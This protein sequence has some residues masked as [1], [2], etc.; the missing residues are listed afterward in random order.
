MNQV[1]IRYANFNRT[2]KI[3]G[4]VQQRKFIRECLQW[5]GTFMGMSAYLKISAQ[6]SCDFCVAHRYRKI[7][8]CLR[9]DSCGADE[10]VD[11]DSKVLLH[12]SDVSRLQPSLSRIRLMWLRAF[13]FWKMSLGALA[14]FRGIFW[15]PGGSAG[16]FLRGF[17]VRGSS[18]R[19]VWGDKTK[20]WHF[21][22][23]LGCVGMQH[24]QLRHN[25]ATCSYCGCKTA[26]FS[27]FAFLV[28]FA[29]YRLVLQKMS[30]FCVTHKILYCG[31]GF[32][33][34]YFFILA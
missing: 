10:G 2:S 12:L 7:N 9:A 27:I 29:T 33:R 3:L 1:I 22:G 23:N 5:K 11:S 32:F 31:Q 16:W 6:P 4:S 20:T 24:P 28:D 26:V 17:G 15:G 34:P 30:L 13:Q 14:I 21:S 25:C 19:V 18:G 8:K